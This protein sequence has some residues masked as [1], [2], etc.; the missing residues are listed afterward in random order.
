MFDPHHAI[1]VGIPVAQ[2]AYDEMNGTDIAA[3]VFTQYLPIEARAAAS[4]HIAKK[5]TRDTHIVGVIGRSGT[6]V[7]VAFRGTQ[8]LEEWVQN[9]TIIPTAFGSLGAVADGFLDLYQL[10]RND[11]GTTLRSTLTMG[12][13]LTVVGHSLGGALAVLAALDISTMFPIEPSVL[14]FGAPR[15]GLHTFATTFNRAIESCFHVSNFLDVVPHVPLPPYLHVGTHVRIDSG[16]PVS[17]SGRHEL[18]SY[19]TGLTKLM[20]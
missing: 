8:T 13:T 15:V 11:M 12:D 19:Q 16:G 18:S 10:V 5:M 9:L 2:A 4:S 6:N 17:L 14:T 3:T 20:H 1:N 7:Y